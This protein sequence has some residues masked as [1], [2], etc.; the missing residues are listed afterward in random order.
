M[1]NF[2]DLLDPESKNFVKSREGRDL[3]RTLERNR[4]TGGRT[5][6]SSFVGGGKSKVIERAKQLLQEG[7]SL[8]SIDRNLAF[9]RLAEALLFNAKGVGITLE[10]LNL[11]EPYLDAI[12][13]RAPS[14]VGIPVS[15]LAHETPAFRQLAADHWVVT[16]QLALSTGQIEAALDVMTRCL[17]LFPD[18]YRYFRQRSVCHAL[19]NEDGLALED[20]DNAC[21][22][23]EKQGYPTASLVVLMAH[24]HR[25]LQAYPEAKAAYHRFLELNTDPLSR[26]KYEALLSLGVIA[27]YVDDYDEALRWDKKARILQANPEFQRLHGICQTSI[28][29][30]LELY[31]LSRKVSRVKHREC[32]AC[33]KVGMLKQCSKCLVDSYC[34]KK[35]QHTAWDAHKIH[36]KRL[37]KERLSEEA[38]RS[39]RLQQKQARTT[40]R[41]KQDPLD[42]NDTGHEV[43]REAE[44]LTKAGQT[45][46]AAERCCYALFLDFRLTTELTGSVVACVLRQG[47]T[48]G[49]LKLPNS[50]RALKELPFDAAQSPWT[51]VLA[52]IAQPGLTGT[53]PTVLWNATQ[54]WLL[55]LLQTEE[56]ALRTRVPGTLVDE[57]VLTS[58]R[59]AQLRRMFAFFL[60]IIG[61][62]VAQASGG[63]LKT[64][65]PPDAET[66][67]QQLR[68]VK[69]AEEYLSPLNLNYLT[70]THELAFTHRDQ[71]ALVESQRH[72]TKFL[73]MA[74]T[75]HPYYTQAED[76]LKLV[77]AMKSGNKS[78]AVKLMI[79]Q[80]E[81]AHD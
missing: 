73:K 41:E 67:K 65:R 53:L 29:G 48:T 76:G 81:M 36:C 39:A 23:A 30:G 22:L 12:S 57:D 13:A 33:G 63:D 8:L 5:V 44:R 16:F 32:A 31:F 7:Y 54:E 71:G 46:A 58:G 64:M 52:V 51:T 47:Q 6:E 14:G 34:D 55:Q 37:C 78:L 70:L 45:E 80:A 43:W 2:K 17:K 62:F 38:A 40:A 9:R 10:E 21:S 68:L 20:L 72:Y 11:L 28:K 24:C 27:S 42:L 19:A 35:C 26:D 66:F 75:S 74:P 77:N 79:K 4:M 1:F 3:V 61:R 69:M 18:E 50:G 15:D 56:A 49:P 60:V 25:N 59:P